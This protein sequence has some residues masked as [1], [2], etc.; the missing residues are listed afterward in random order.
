MLPQKEESVSISTFPRLNRIARSILSDEAQIFFDE[1]KEK[2]IRPQGSDSYEEHEY[3]IS[4]GRTKKKQPSILLLITGV[5]LGRVEVPDDKEL[6]VDIIS[7]W[8]KQFKDANS[9]TAAYARE[10]FKFS[11][12]HGLG[13]L[14][15]IWSKNHFGHMSGESPLSVLDFAAINEH[16]ERFFS[17]RRFSAWLEYGWL[18][19]KEEQDS[20]HWGVK[21]GK[22]DPEVSYVLSDAGIPGFKKRKESKKQS[23]PEEQGTSRTANIGVWSEVGTFLSIASQGFITIPGSSNQKMKVKSVFLDGHTAELTGSNSGSLYINGTSKNKQPFEIERKWAEGILDNWM[24]NFVHVKDKSLAPKTSLAELLNRRSGGDGYT[25]NTSRNKS[26]ISIVCEDGNGKDKKYH[27]S[28]KSFSSGA[29]TLFN[30]SSGSA[31]EFELEAE[32][33]DDNLCKVWRDDYKE[34]HKAITPIVSIAKNGANAKFLRFI[35][36]DFQNALESIDK[37]LPE[38]IAVIVACSQKFH[39][40]SH[41]DIA[42][43]VDHLSCNQH[44][45]PRSISESRD[46]MK[47]TH[48]LVSKWLSAI[49]TE[50]TST[51]I[52]RAPGAP[53]AFAFSSV[54][55]QGKLI[56]KLYPFDKFDISD[57]LYLSSEICTPSRSKHIS[58]KTP[59]ADYP[60]TFPHFDGDRL[61]VRINHQVRLSPLPPKPAVQSGR[62]HP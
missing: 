45:L 35:S 27:V 41:K 16:G 28:I 51:G 15:D 46:P 30:A 37:D 50:L 24:D 17:P 59:H 7:S 54:D 14:N 58:D 12:R 53:D 2:R 32:D 9:T 23:K 48:K 62:A 1:I 20:I 21:E 47:K 22:L 11:V 6:I 57:I 56:V 33:V 4:E 34:G 42:G 36:E 25:P 61:V 49:S 18:P 31:A 19:N 43:I 5:I 38:L 44:L 26:D 40:C 13:G 60:D 8:S 55:G 52:C 29:P 3:L 39:G 10:W